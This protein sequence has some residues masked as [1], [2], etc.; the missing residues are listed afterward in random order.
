MKRMMDIFLSLTALVILCPLLLLIACSVALLLGRPVLFKQIRPGRDGQLFRMVKFRTM[1]LLHDESGNLLPD[2][3]RLSPFGRFLRSM[4][5]DE[6]PEIWNVLKGDMSIV[7][8]RPLLP[9]YLPLYSEK[10]RKR[11]DVRPGITGWAQVNGRN[12]ITWEDRLDMDVWYVENQSFCLDL[13]ILWRTISM[14]L[15]RKGVSA[16]GH[17][18]MSPFTGYSKENQ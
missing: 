13:K 4:S 8:P 9:E 16:Q 7:G 17:V 3:L 18:T 5:L 1:S 6:L 2:H 11:H 14:V 10:H 12:L 15:T